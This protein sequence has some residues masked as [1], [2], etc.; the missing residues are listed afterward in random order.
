MEAPL[1][2]RWSRP[3][4]DGAEPSTVTVSRDTAGRSFVSILVEADI[5]PLPPVARDVG[6]DLGVHDVVVLDSGEKIG[7]P[8]CFH[9][10]EQRL[11]KVQRRLARTQQGSKHRKRPASKSPAFT[12][13]SPT[14]A[15]TSCTSSPRASSVRTKGFAWRACV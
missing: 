10:D 11:A 9:R 5:Q 8:T 15:R 3:M 1:A 6:S 13:G 14:V 12:L 2:I 4:P 7:N